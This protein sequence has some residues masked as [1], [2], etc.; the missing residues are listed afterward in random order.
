MHDAEYTVDDN[1]HM[2]SHRF[3]EL[4]PTVEILLLFLNEV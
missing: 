4:N 1:L 2:D 3:P